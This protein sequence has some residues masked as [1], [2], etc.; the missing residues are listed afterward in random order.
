M[1]RLL[2]RAEAS[3]TM[4]TGHVMRCLALGQ[5]WQHAG[6]EVTFAMAES[7]PAIETRIRRENF[8]VA[9]LPNGPAREECTRVSALAREHSAR[10][11][12]VD[13]YHFDADYQRALKEDGFKLLVVDD[14]GAV[15]HYFADLVLNQNVYARED[16]YPRR[17]AYTELLLGP[18]YAM[19]RRE[20]SAWRNWQRKVARP[21]RRVLVTLGG[22]DPENLTLRVI[23]SLALLDDIEASVVVGGSNPHGPKLEAAV[24]QS[25]GR[26]RLLKEASM[27]EQMAWAD[28]AVCG[29][30]TTALEL[31]F[32]GLP[33][34][35]IDIAPNQTPVARELAQRGVAVH[36]DATARDPEQIAVQIRQL[37]FDFETREEMSKAGQ[38]LVDGRGVERVMAAMSG[39]EIRIRNA[40]SADS[41]QLFAWANEP[42]VRAASFREGPIPWE[43]HIA[44]FGSQ[45]SDPNARVYMGLDSRENP[46]GVVR[47]RLAGERATVSLTVDGNVRGKGHGTRMLKMAVQELFRSSS[48]RA[49]DAYVKTENEASQRLFCSAGFRRVNGV[50]TV[51]SHPSVHFVL[52]KNEG[53]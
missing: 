24:A 23:T 22:S 51:N 29:A 45:L 19:L 44:W 8:E 16:S 49:V 41:R 52:A 13:G 38:A 9:T 33:S 26:I 40:D 20:F 7:T 15:S 10:W 34:I 35:L 2:I 31:C 39:G 48:A 18:R 36:L 46:I 30:G 47:F 53:C 37:L 5:A 12:V 14:A 32:F 27:P 3:V 4:G 21:A 50:E 28:L 6:G 1:S 11:L 25:A 17:E 42:A 43:Q